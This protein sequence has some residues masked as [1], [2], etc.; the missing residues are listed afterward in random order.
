MKTKHF[1]FLFRLGFFLVPLLWCNVLFSQ[2]YFFKNFT[3]ENGL[4]QSQVLSV[5]QD[6]SGRLWIGTNQEGVARY[7]GDKFEYFKQINGLA[8]NVVYSIAQGNEGNL[9]IGTVNG[10]SIYN[11]KK[12]N[13]YTTEKG[14]SHNGVVKV[15][16]DKKGKILLGTGK[17]VCVLEG[18]TIIPLK[19][20]S[21]LDNSTVFN[22]VED[23]KGNTWFCTVQSGLFLF[24]GGK[25]KNYSSA[26]GLK[27]NYVYSVIQRGTNNYWIATHEGLY[28][29]ENEKITQ[30]KVPGTMTD[31]PFYDFCKDD[32]GN[33]WIGSSE[34]VFKYRNGE[35]TKFKKSNGLVDNNI[36]KIIQDREGNMWFAS[37]TNGLSKL[38]SEMFYSYN[39]RDSLPDDNI[40]AIF[41]DSSGLYWIGSKR[42]ATTFDGKKFTTYKEKN[43]LS[44]E[45]VT[46]FG[47][48]KNGTILIGTNFGLTKYAGKKFTELKADER[49]CNHIQD[50]HVEAD[51]TIWL[52]TWGG[53]AKVEGNK[54]IPFKAADKFRD[55]TYCIYKDSE[56]V[57]WF[58]YEDGVLRYNG[59]GVQHMNKSNGF[60][61]DRIRCIDED[62]D[63]NL[64]FG[65]NDGLYKYNRR[66]LTHF[67]EK[68]GLRSS[69][70]YSLVF[71][72]N[73]S[74][75]L[76]M[77]KGISHITAKGDVL[78]RNRYYGKDDGFPGGCSNN[79]MMIDNK[80]K[81]WIGTAN[82]LVVYQP[83]FDLPKNTEPITVLKAIRLFSQP[84][85]W[86]LFADSVDDNNIPLNLVLTFD[87]NHL[88]FD[89]VGI[90]LTNP[91]EIAY[92]YYLKGFDKGWLPVSFKTSETYSNLPPGEYEFLVKSGTEEDIVTA[93]PVSFKFVIE[94]PFW[95]RWWFFLIIGLLVA[96][97]IY[98]Y[99]SIRRANS[100][101]TRQKEE[102]SLQKDIIEH[103][104]RDITD[105][106]NYAKTLQEAILPPQQVFKKYLKD[107]F[108]LY[109]PKDIVSGDFYWIEKRG[110]NVMLSVA[111]CTGHGV[112]GAFMSIIGHNGL[113]QAVNEHR[114]LKPSIILNYLNLTV[115]E[116][117]HKAAEGASVRDGMDMALCNF[118]TKTLELEYAGAHNPLFIISKGELT[119][120]KADRMSIGQFTDEP[121][122]FTNHTY[123]LQPGDSFYMFSDGIVDQFG[124][125]K[126]KK[127]KKAQLRELLQTLGHLPMEE[128]KARI[129]TY[130]KQ[131]M[132]NHE[133]VDD[134]CIIGVKA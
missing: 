44:S 55:K 24:S 119:E 19:L 66:Y 68:E 71:D 59:T 26:N 72:K 100:Q 35:F 126:G 81:I 79:A 21:V 16:K 10:L 4:P 133:Q 25:L 49:N 74:M 28:N 43:G 116:T 11:G 91:H 99:V 32:A 46:C 113:N 69:A 54:I 73:N 110:D 63:W 78:N 130:Y 125:D 112:P 94:P 5:F 132:G 58:G 109:M 37:K 90:S 65:T 48:E 124:G 118:N 23:N 22:I 39:I 115:N 52:A 29:L 64:W 97:A 2:T 92:Q 70:V 75:W 128:Q 129:V 82:G 114:L 83:E 12:F 131:W 56:G 103:K 101:I 108:I 87:R 40:E 7:D 89:Y 13:N 33:L 18:D 105:S 3:V 38:S 57:L 34:G 20:D 93:K 9:Y 51:G 122:S 120:L 123:Q 80:G 95:Q 107:T 17:G 50:I 96:A 42:G 60:I 6:A 134:M 14:L 36:W 106:I 27:S 61:G 127:F 104:N 62:E 47:Q 1:T 76:G 15:F 41:Q 8:N 84:V 67:G 86:K 121:K 102:I 98:S 53:I 88:T 30:V 117:L 77:P 111:D 45:T 31:I 85:E